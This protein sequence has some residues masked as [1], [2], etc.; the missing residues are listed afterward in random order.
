MP[1]RLLALLLLAGLPG[2][3]RAQCDG[4]EVIVHTFSGI[5]AWELE[6]SLVDGNGDVLADYAW[7]DNLVTTADT[8]VE[9]QTTAGVGT[10]RRDPSVY[11]S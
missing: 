8:V 5:A 11:S 6:W 7:T 3:L 10:L 1:F 2:L 4:T 9:I